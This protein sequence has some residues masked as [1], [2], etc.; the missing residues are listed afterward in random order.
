MNEKKGKVRTM[1][2]PANLCPPICEFLRISAFFGAEELLLSACSRASAVASRASLVEAAA[3]RGG[4]EE[5]SSRSVS[6]CQPS[7]SRECVKSRGEFDQLACLGCVDR[8]PT[9]FETL[10]GDMTACVAFLVGA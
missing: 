4:L 6:T 3:S 10:G 8:R 7:D 1:T 9:C 2:F 5:R